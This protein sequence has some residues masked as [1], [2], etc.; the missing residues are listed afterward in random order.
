MI[1]Y[2]FLQKCK[3]GGPKITMLNFW[4]SSGGSLIVFWGYGLS[5]CQRIV[6]LRSCFKLVSILV[7]IVSL[8]VKLMDLN[9]KLKAKCF[10]FQF[11]YFPDMIHIMNIKF[12]SSPRAGSPSVHN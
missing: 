11:D 4:A 7:K 3:T 6:L 10:P 5:Q 8:L 9:F 12:G 1:N 2:C